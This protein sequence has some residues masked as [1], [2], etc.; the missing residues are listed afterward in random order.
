MPVLVLKKAV[1]ITAKIKSIT[2][3][4]SKKQSPHHAQKSK[5]TLVGF[6]PTRSKSNGLAIHR[7]NHSAT[8]SVQVKWYLKEGVQC[9]TNGVSQTCLCLLLT[10]SKKKDA[11]G[12]E[13]R[14]RAQLEVMIVC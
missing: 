8:M 10:F 11:S 6:E 14:F 9:V 3:P 7:L 12:S 2:S 4:C 5:A 1:L 13:K